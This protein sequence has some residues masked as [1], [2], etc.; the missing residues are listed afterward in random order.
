LDKNTTGLLL[1]TNDGELSKR[2]THPSF[3]SKKIYQV[4][5]DNPVTKQDLQQIADG[6]TLD[7]GLIAADQISYLDPEDRTEVGIEIHSG[8]N[9]VV[10]RMFEH[11]GYNVRKL[12]RV[13]YAGL[14]KKDLPRGRF[15][16][17][18]LQ[19]INFLKMS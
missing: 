6:I 15:R 18:S 7:D 2:L 19:E 1:F 10:R 8:R 3:N 5:L 13:F 17:L 11:L 14:T 4:T 9:R 12:D 16:F